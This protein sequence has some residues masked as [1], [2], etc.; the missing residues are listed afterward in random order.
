[1]VFMKVEQLSIFLQN[2]EGSLHDVLEILKKGNLNLKALSLADASDFGILRI[3]VDNPDK[4]IKLLKDNGFLVKPTDIIAIEMDDT[5]GALANILGII[6]KDKI[7]LE[8]LYAFSHQKTD[9]AIL[10]L[11][12]DNLDDLISCLEKENIVIVQ[13]EKIFDL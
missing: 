11:H 12:T 9:K 8:Y 2:K 10:V 7:N 4:G 3:V 13:S 6:K 5:P 1:M